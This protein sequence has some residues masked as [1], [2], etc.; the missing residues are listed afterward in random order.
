MEDVKINVKLKLSA[1]WITLMFLY[2]YADILSLF[3]PGA[4]EEIIAGDL[5]IGSQKSLLAA[6]MLMMI[7]NVMVFLSLALK[8]KV[9]RGANIIAGLFYTGINLF[10]NLI[11][12]LLSDAPSAYWIFFACVEI[13][14]SALIVWYAWKW[15]KQ[16]G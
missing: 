14:L 4:I 15:P 10:M 3:E 7:P 2:I 9:N 8:A 16:E 5:P 13:V 1:L 6:A 12:E 11:L